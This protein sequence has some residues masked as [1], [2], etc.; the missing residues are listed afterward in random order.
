[1]NRRWS[2]Y[3]LN[4]GHI[5]PPLWYFSQ[6]RIFLSFL[7][8]LHRNRDL[9]IAVVLNMSHVVYLRALKRKSTENL[10]IRRK[11]LDLG[12]IFVKLVQ[13]GCTADIE[14]FWRILQ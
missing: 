10:S 13:L 2:S 9:L 8:I 1:M 7:A 4:R 12:H 11:S 5:A 6:K 3:R 14:R